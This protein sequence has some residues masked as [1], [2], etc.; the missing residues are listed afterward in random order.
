M[1]V[2]D[3]I[4]ISPGVTL[5][6]LCL[7]NNTAQ[8]VGFW[9]WDRAVFYAD[10]DISKETSY[11]HQEIQGCGVRN[12][13][14]TSIR[15]KTGSEEKEPGQPTFF[16]VN[17]RTRNFKNKRPFSGPQYLSSQKAKIKYWDVRKDDSFQSHG[18]Q[19]V[20][21]EIATLV[22][23]STWPDGVT[24]ETLLPLKQKKIT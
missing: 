8:N 5:Y 15:D 24:S 23:S 1:H 18:Q 21:C 17:G 20:E 10:I 12:K 6:C 9:L 16:F 14:A 7:E 2:T 3:I 19:E 11:P 4:A 22:S 13:L